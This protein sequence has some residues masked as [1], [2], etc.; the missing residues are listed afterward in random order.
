MFSWTFSAQLTMGNRNA[1][2]KLTTGPN[3]G[4]THY[5]N[6]RPSPCATLQPCYH[7]R[8]PSNVREHSNISMKV[9]YRLSSRNQLGLWIIFSIL[10]L[11]WLALLSTSDIELKYLLPSLGLLALCCFTLPVIGTFCIYVT[12]DESALTAP[13][14]LLFHRAI[15]INNIVALHLRPHAI[16]LMRGIE[17]EYITHAGRAKTARI[18][19]FTT[20]GRKKTEE[21][22]HH[23]TD[24]NPQI[25]VDPNISK[26]LRN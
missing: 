2:N 9:A 25:K 17:I 20:F 21:M 8:M 26:L 13:V 18:P 24:I 4:S 5:L 14:G 15:P 6:E 7:S 1:R 10:F 3:F 23:L 22:I 16:G 11:Y 12:I 19:S